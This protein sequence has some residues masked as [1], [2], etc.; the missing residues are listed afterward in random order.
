MRR[1]ITTITVIAA[2]SII[3]AACGEPTVES[4]PAA[5]A[6]PDTTAAPTTEAPASEAPSA[7]PV[8]GNA[9]NTELIAAIE[10][11]IDEFS[12]TTGTPGA[13]AAVLMPSENGLI[14]ITAGAG[15]SDITSGDAADPNDHYRWASITKPMTSTLILQLVEEGL[16]DLDE[17][18]ATYL[19]GDWA[20][21]YTF[22]G[23]DYAPLLTIRQ[24]LNHTDGFAE[25][26]FDVGFFAQAAQRM[27]T[28]FEPEEIVAWGIGRGPQYTP[29]D[30]YAYN[31]VGH[32]V[33]GLVIEAVTGRGAHEVM[34]ERL[35]DPVDADD[36]YLTP[37]EFP[38]NN[39]VAGYAR[40]ELKTAFDVLP[41]LADYRADATVGEFFDVT[42][43]PEAVVR[44]AGWTGGG[45]EAQADDVARVFRSMFTG[46]LTE[47]SVTAFTT[48]FRDT[49][50]GLGISVGESAG[51]TSYSH[52]G[53]VPGFRSDA[54]YLPDLDVTV[55]VSANLIPIEPD[56]SSLS[57]AILDLVL[58]RLDG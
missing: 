2:L 12:A 51:H 19:G 49:G 57:S 20:S 9:D 22:D 38:P 14:Q 54:V 37:A 47:E 26:A 31:T 43:P 27:E 1:Q 40:A 10:A 35:F 46:A 25:Y 7:T 30:G 5:A 13:V 55:V 33:A 50:Y 11:A 39:D 44:S 15:L 48:P 4:E 23:V 18:V 45:L 52:G 21:D 32:V 42:V 17:P 36:A 28:P 16:I 53:G 29:G 34:R 3:V 41:G 8:D 24:I 56:I 58:E 6:T